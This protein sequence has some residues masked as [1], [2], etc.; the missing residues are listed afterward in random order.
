VSEEAQPLVVYVEDEVLLQEIAI[1]VLSEAGYS[2]AAY[3]TGSEAMAALEAPDQT[4]RALV[5]DIDLRGEPNGWEVARRARELFPD[6]PII[7]VSG[8]SSHEW[9]SMGVPGSVL[10]T[11]PPMPSRNSSSR[12]RTPCSGR[13]NPLPR[14]VRRNATRTQAKERTFAGFRCGGARCR[15]GFI[16]ETGTRPTRPGPGQTPGAPAARSKR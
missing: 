14:R 8:G 6:L 1:T 5:T 10:V 11:K 15:P 12:F 16:F 4:I 2:V 9:T 3:L 13:P 7:Y